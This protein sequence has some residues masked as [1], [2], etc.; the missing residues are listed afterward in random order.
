M[1]WGEEIVHLVVRW[2]GEEMRVRLGCCLG[3]FLIRA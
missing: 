2:G 3:Y 1:E